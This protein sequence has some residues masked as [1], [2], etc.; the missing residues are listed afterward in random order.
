MNKDDN[1]FGKL[2]YAKRA[3]QACLDNEACLVDMHGLCYWAS[4]VDTL[5]KRIKEDM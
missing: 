3:C 2:V 5:R 1:I 4:M